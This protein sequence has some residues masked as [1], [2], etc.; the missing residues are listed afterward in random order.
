M[1]Y[2]ILQDYPYKNAYGQYSYTNPSTFYL[3]VGLETK[4]YEDDLNTVVRTL[5]FGDQLFDS[6]IDVFCPNMSPYNFEF[7]DVE[8]VI[9]TLDDSSEYSC[10]V[11]DGTENPSLSDCCISSVNYTAVSSIRPITD[12]KI[13]NTEYY[14]QQYYSDNVIEY[15]GMTAP[16]FIEFSVDLALNNNY[17]P[18][19]I[20]ESESSINVVVVDW[21]TSGDIPTD[22][23]LLN[24][25]N[26]IKNK[27]SMQQTGVNI[28]IQHFYQTPGLKTISAIVEYKKELR[29]GTTCENDLADFSL[30]SNGHG[31]VF[32][33]LGNFVPQYLCESQY[34][35]NWPVDLGCI[36]EFA[37][38]DWFHDAEDGLGERPG[39]NGVAFLT[40][41]NGND[42]MQQLE[43]L[44][45]FSG[46]GNYIWSILGECEIDSLGYQ[47]TSGIDCTAYT[48]YATSG[49]YYGYSGTS[50]EFLGQ[51]GS[52]ITAMINIR[53]FIINDYCNRFTTPPPDP[54]TISKIDLVTSKFYLY[55]DEIYK[56]EFEEIGGVGFDYLPW[57]ETTP[58]IGGISDESK[59]I[60]DVINIVNQNQFKETEVLDK[61]KATE[62]LEND[63]MG[64]H[65]GKVD[66]SQA[67]VFLGARDMDTLLMVDTSNEYTPYDD[68]TYWCGHEETC[69]NNTVN[70][71]SLYSCVGLLF[72]SDSTD[73]TL[74]DDCIVEF[75]FGDTSDDIIIDTSG[76][77]NKGIII[78]DYS[79]QKSS[80]ETP[81]IRD[82]VMTT[83]TTDIE[84]GAY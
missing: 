20:T 8:E 33:H 19:Y 42:V 14:L 84:N 43:A 30:L 3:D 59:Y 38:T 5:Q 73:S 28:P 35:A 49:L 11:V 62:A 66:I 54:I 32:H 25:Y 7:S 12:I 68:F 77:N 36:D 48:L 1:E 80:K 27:P 61:Q 13:K 76:Q 56:D 29:V 44:K 60:N 39:W 6:S 18:E 9:I 37:E 10:Y 16:N 52:G 71:Y 69:D 21:N 2:R 41:E 23:E 26:G 83:P 34:T 63:E 4:L 24:M 74:R 79:L 40:D 72:I 75:N 64:N 58:I 47:D 15:I 17:I 78:G 31:T 67:R 51:P 57:P 81:L 82:D 50:L 46:T 65:L 53:D 55:P 45:I 22:G 70:T